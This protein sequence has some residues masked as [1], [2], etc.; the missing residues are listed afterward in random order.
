MATDLVQADRYPHL[1]EHTLVAE[2]GTQ[3][4]FLGQPVASDRRCSSCATDTVT[5]YRGPQYGLALDGEV[6]IELAWC[7]HHGQ[8]DMRLVCPDGTEYVG[9]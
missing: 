1:T 3:T 7:R 2:T 6:E 5:I 4:R 9:L 8:A